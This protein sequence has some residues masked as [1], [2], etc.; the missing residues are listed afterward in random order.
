[1]VTPTPGE[2]LLE[3]KSELNQQ[4]LICLFFADFMIDDH[5]TTFL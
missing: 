4:Q 5:K 1:M 3:D 2:M